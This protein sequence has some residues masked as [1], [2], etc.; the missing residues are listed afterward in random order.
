VVEIAKTEQPV[1]VD[2]AQQVAGRMASKIAKLLIE[3]KHVVV[4]NAETSLMSGSKK[5]I[6]AE[7]MQ[8]KELKSI[9]N[10]INAPHRPRQP[11]MILNRMIR[12]ML[13]RRK[14]KGQNAF[15]RLK[16]HIGIPTPYRTVEKMT[17]EDAKPKKQLQLY[18]TIGEIAVNQGWRK[19]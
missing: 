7:Y 16:V 2:A 17:F 4:L 19:R 8:R 9:V 12:G 11:N 3:G 5:N 18:V 14:P 1:V 6:F 15:K 13:P 10:P